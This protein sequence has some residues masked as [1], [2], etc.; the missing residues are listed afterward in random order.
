MTM[1]AFSTMLYL[2]AKG[3]SRILRKPDYFYLGGCGL[4]GR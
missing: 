1:N 4:R 3:S 2:E